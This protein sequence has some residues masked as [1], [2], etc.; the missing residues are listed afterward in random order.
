MQE[1][2]T[3]GQIVELAQR[4]LSLGRRL[5]RTRSDDE[6]G[7]RLERLYRRLR[8]ENRRL[9]LENER[10]RA[11]IKRI[12]GSRSNDVTHMCV[13]HGNNSPAFVNGSV[14]FT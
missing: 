11:T 7:D 2:S 12:K 1:P 5:S 13:T 4:D 6:G 3:D 10:L 8:E 9:R 14:I